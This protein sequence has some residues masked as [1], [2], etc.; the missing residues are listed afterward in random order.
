[1][2]EVV[3]AMNGALSHRGPD[4]EGAWV[5]EQTGVAF[6][7]RRLSIIDLSD[8]GRQPMLS[9]SGRYVITFNGEIYNYRALHDEL[10]ALGSSF[11]G[12][13]DTE[14]LLAAIE[15]WGLRRALERAVGMFAIAVWDRKERTLQ[16]VRDRVGEKPL[17]YGE[18]RGN[19]FFASE[20]KALCAYPAWQPTVDSTAIALLLR[21]SCIPA[22]Y[23]IYKNVRKVMPGTIVTF[24]AGVPAEISTYWTLHETAKQA[25]ANRFVG[26]QQEALEELERLLR[27]SLKDQMSASDVPLG[28]FLSGGIDSSAVVALMQTQSERSIQTFTIGFHEKQYDEATHAKAVAQ[29]LGTKHT[30]LYV[31]SQD[32][33]SVIPRLPHL[34]DEPFADPSQIPTYLLAA[35]TRR[36]VT[37]ALSGDGGDE[38]FGGYNRYF[39][40]ESIWK[41]RQRLLPLGRAMVSGGIRALSPKAWDALFSQVLIFMPPSMRPRLLGEGLYKVDRILK[42]SGPDE[43]YAALISHCDAADTVVR[44]ASASVLLQPLAE[45][46]VQAPVDRM[47][48]WDTVGYLP[49][50]ILVK[51]DR[52]TMGVG[53]EARAPFL[54]HRLIEFA[55]RLPLSLKVGEGK[56]KLLLRQLLYRYVPASLVERPKMGFGVPIDSWLRGPLREWAQAL[57]DAKRL[58]A[59]GIFDPDFVERRWQE[60]LRGQR[61][62]QYLLWNI[63]MFQAWHEE[64]TV[65]SRASHARNYTRSHA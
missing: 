11:K 1:M 48:Y 63:L 61:N 32:A 57:L 58:R 45:P 25:T 30:E 36:T 22:P 55:W 24:R 7:H 50:D 56:G 20:V 64:A 29:H 21:Y 49:N 47:M 43:A 23:S 52:A 42:A 27:A 6:G 2:R 18:E 60:H 59:E 19:V 65:S 62:W 3:S 46:P 13:S 51:V 54:D 31:T 40:A 33:L 44:G 10:A 17:F 16:L 41:W 39:L 12:H 8:N 28:A 38:L 37:V 35:L 14:V 5:D 4:G 34:Y 15:Q 53:L 9:S 26:D